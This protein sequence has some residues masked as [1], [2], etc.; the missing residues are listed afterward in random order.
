MQASFMRDNAGPSSTKF[1]V[2]KEH[3]QC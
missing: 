1:D 2:V 3:W